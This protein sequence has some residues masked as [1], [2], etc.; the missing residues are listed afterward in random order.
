MEYYHIIKLDSIQIL[1]LIN[2]NFDNNKFFSSLFKPTNHVIITTLTT[3]TRQTNM[4]V[5]NVLVVNNNFRHKGKTED[6]ISTDIVGNI[7]FIIYLRIE[8]TSIPFNTN[9]LTVCT[10]TAINK[11]IIST[12]SGL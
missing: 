1:F 4:Q 3:E 7:T 9:N 10:S 2:F 6:S 12:D 8:K 11:L 5:I